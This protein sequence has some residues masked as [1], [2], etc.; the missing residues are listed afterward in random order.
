MKNLA[1]D[2]PARS[3]RNRIGP[4]MDSLTKPVLTI[5]IAKTGISAKFYG[6]DER[7]FIKEVNLVT[8][9]E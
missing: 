2:S 6:V 4:L 8:S 1:S 9:L 7:A 5:D 3:Q